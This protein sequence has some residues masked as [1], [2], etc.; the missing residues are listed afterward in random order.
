MK[1]LLLS[2]VFIHALTGCIM[3]PIDIE[4]DYSRMPVSK[5]QAKQIMVHQSTVQE[6]VLLLGEPDIISSKRYHYVWTRGEI[7][8][9]HTRGGHTIIKSYLFNVTFDNSGVVINKKFK[10]YGWGELDDNVIE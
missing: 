3:F 5:S 9:L 1:T 8:M 10:D 4:M 6:V 2:A 7:L